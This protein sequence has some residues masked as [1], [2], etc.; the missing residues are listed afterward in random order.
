MATPPKLTRESAQRLSKVTDDAIDDIDAYGTK[1]NEALAKAA[2][3]HALPV[4]H[5]PLLVRGY[6]N[7]R[8]A[9]QLAA[10]TNPWERAA[11]FDPADVDGVT[12]ALAGSNV[13]QASDLSDYARPPEREVVV[14]DKAALVKK[15][16]E[17]WGVSLEEP[18]T[19]KQA[20][21]PA[22]VKAPSYTPT[23]ALIEVSSLMQKF[24]RELEE[25]AC[26][27]YAAVKD[28]CINQLGAH[29]ECV[30]K[31]AEDRYPVFKKAASDEIDLSVPADHPACKIVEA[32][33]AVIADT[34][35]KNQDVTKEAY[36]NVIGRMLN[37]PGVF[38]SAIK[39][40]LAGP[41]STYGK[42][43]GYFDT[44]NQLVQ[45]LARRQIDNKYEHLFKGTDS[46]LT[47]EFDRIDQ[48]DVVNNLLA[49]PRLKGVDPSAV[50]D[51]YRTLSGLAPT[52]MRNHALAADLIHRVSQTGPLSYFD[53][54]ELT[55][56]EKNMTDSEKNRRTND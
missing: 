40:P 37:R 21:A 8:T 30:F 46:K 23:A 25:A 15:A 38:S 1:P 54:K 14:K 33:D 18:T 5:V 39:G 55:G 20:S 44:K 9:E 17:L 34:S 50:I 31:F 16:A 47:R 4:G 42:Y 22:K 19:V 7:A 11:D 56:I 13:K 6:N 35:F 45:G 24:A 53:L 29:A 32:I 48:Q 10:S 12:Q 27:T 3:A 36:D 49:D 28:H 51:S 26:G 52:A 43:K 2:Q 41:D